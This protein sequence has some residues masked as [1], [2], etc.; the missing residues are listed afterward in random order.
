LAHSDGIIYDRLTDLY[1]MS[2]PECGYLG[3][4]SWGEAQN[5]LYALNQGQIPE[6]SGQHEDWRIPNVLEMASLFDYGQ[7]GNLSKMVDSDLFEGAKGSRYW[8]SSVYGPNV[9][10]NLAINF[11]Y[12]TISSRFRPWEDAR[13]WPVRRENNWTPIPY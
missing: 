12:G 7:E 5:Y 4:L 1:W 8:T 9:R 13:V 3:A 2:N 10:Y 6:C 11:G